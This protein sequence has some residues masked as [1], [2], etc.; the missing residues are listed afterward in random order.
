M[1]GEESVSGCW[2][3]SSVKMAREEGLQVEMDS[4][5]TS[6]GVSSRIVGKGH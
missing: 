3:N 6:E 2:A 4:G 1:V 5:G